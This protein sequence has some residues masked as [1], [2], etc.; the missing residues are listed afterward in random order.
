[1]IEKGG[2][3]DGMVVVVFILPTKLWKKFRRKKRAKLYQ[4]LVLAPSTLHAVP[5]PMAEILFYCR[6]SYCVLCNFIRAV[7]VLQ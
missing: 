6:I 4:T 3:G 2:L 1:M 5:M 7:I